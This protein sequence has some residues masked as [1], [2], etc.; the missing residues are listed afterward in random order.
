MNVPSWLLGKHSGLKK[1]R[2]NYLIREPP[3]HK[4][5]KNKKSIVNKHAENESDV[6]ILI[7]NH[8]DVAQIS[9]VTNSPF[10]FS[11]H[12]TWMDEQMEIQLIVF[13]FN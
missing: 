6:Q 7:F 3:E 9:I 13:M 8:L 5:Q 10:H 4:T 11:I 2:R 1:R 12:F